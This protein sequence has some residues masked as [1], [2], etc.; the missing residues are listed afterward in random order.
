VGHQLI[1]Y[2][3][4]VVSAFF[5]WHALLNITAIKKHKEFSS[6]SLHVEKGK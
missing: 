3:E 1:K 5:S 6:M 2:K 4:L